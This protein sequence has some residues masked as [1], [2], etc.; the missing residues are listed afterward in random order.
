VAH[1]ALHPPQSAGL[2][3]VFTQAVPHAAPVQ[4]VL[5]FAGEDEVSHTGS[6]PEQAPPH[7][8]QLVVVFR[9]VSQPS[10]GSPLQ[11]PH[12]G[13]HE[14]AGNEQRADTHV[15][16]PLT[17]GRLVQSFAHDPHVAGFVRSVE[18][19]V[20]APVQSAKPAAHE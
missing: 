11:S 9:G 15:V 12:P 16:G 20:P 19:P 18:Q 5:H 17:C 10:V 2:F 3:V 4:L 7:D 1:A 13:A 14:V 6:T 8:P